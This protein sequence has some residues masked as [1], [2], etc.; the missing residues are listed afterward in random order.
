[1]TASTFTVIVQIIGVTNIRFL[2]VSFIGIDPTFPHHLNSFDNVPVSYG[3]TLVNVTSQDP[4]NTIYY[5]NTINYT[6]QVGITSTHNKFL[7][8]FSRNKIL[9]FMTSMYVQGNNEGDPA[10]GPF[11][12]LCLTV[13]T[14]VIY[15]D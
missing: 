1:L 4:I 12:P 3:S 2:C 7:T 9:L 10:N 5:S 6:Q 11:N 8:P 14:Y 13:D 15:V